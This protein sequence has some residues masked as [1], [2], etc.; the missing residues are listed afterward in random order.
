MKFLL[1]LLLLFPS[2]S[3]A[4]GI[5]IVKITPGSS[6]STNDSRIITLESSSYGVSNYTQRGAYSRSGPATS[7][8]DST[9]GKHGDYGRFGR[10]GDYGRY[11][12]RHPSNDRYRY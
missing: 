7:R 5:R 10:Y 6:V 9:Y 1:A 3:Y 8:D 11:Y 2:I 12:N 4:Q